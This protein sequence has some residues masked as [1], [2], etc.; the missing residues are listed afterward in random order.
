MVRDLLREQSLVWVSGMRFLIATLVL[1]IVASFRLPQ[2]ELF[3]GFR[4]RATWKWM[5]PMALTGPFLATLFWVAGFKYT[6]AGRAAIYNQLST[7]FI[8]LFAWIILREQMTG[9]RW[10]G[11]A[12]AATGAVLVASK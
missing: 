3:A 6:L 2:R 11:V 12:L 4:E 7:V 5:I 10:L 9:R 1:G 8:I